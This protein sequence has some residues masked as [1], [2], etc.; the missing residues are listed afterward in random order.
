MRPGSRS[1][2]R[3]ATLLEA[4]V[5]LSIFVTA[6]ASCI[7]LVAQS[8]DAVVRA[9]ESAESLR[10][11]SAY[12][13]VV[14]LWTREDYDRHLGTHNQGPWQMSVQRVTPDLYEIALLDSTA[15][16]ELLRTSVYR[17][18]VERGIAP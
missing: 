2:R 3:G 14:T 15:Q 12:L 8:L 6:A 7:A 9:R 13:D 16:R 5:A 11:A 18:P 10:A 1:L 4:I 17:R